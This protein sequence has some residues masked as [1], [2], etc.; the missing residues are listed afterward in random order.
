MSNWT[1][2][3]EFAEKVQRRQRDIFVKCAQEVQRS[4]QEGSEI[5]SAPG[6]P[7]QFGNLKGSWIPEF[8]GRWTWQ[9]MT[10]AEYARGI[11]DGMGPNG[12]LTLR[13]PVGG[14]HS[15]KLTRNGWEKIVKKVNK[16]VVSGN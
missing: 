16:E 10:N 9:T 12:P 7:V 13:S 1:G 15:V 11:E 5:T 3:K 2:L 6:Q 14:F 8:T 4:V